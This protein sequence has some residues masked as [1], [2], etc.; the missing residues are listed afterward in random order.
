[1]SVVFSPDGKSLASASADTTILI[2]DTLTFGQSCRQDRNR[3]VQSFCPVLWDDLAGDDAAK[4]YRAIR[5]LA[6]CRSK[7]SPICKAACNPW[8]LPMPS[9]SNASLPTCT[10][11]ASR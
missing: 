5:A 11:R 3:P 9:A 10:A 4:A 6:W 7:L 1:M 2:W 8:Q